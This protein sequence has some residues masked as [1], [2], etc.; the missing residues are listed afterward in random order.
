MRRE[1]I[2]S[3][4]PKRV[5][6]KSKYMLIIPAVA[7]VTNVKKK[8]NIIRKNTKTGFKSND[9]LSWKPRVNTSIVSKADTLEDVDKDLNN[10]SIKSNSHGSDSIKITDGIVD[11]S[12]CDDG[13]TRNNGI[14]GADSAVNEAY[15]RDGIN[16]DDN[17][18]CS[19]GVTNGDGTSAGTASMACNTDNGNSSCSGGVTNGDGTSAGTASMACN[20]DNG[21]SSCSGG[22]T[23][24][25]DT[26]AGTASMACNTD[27]SNKVEVEDNEE[28]E[29]EDEFDDDTDNEEEEASFESHREY[30]FYKEI[31][32]EV[33]YDGFIRKKLSKTRTTHN[34]EYSCT[35]CDGM[36]DH[37]MNQIYMKCICKLS[38][39]KFGY[40]Y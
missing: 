4:R 23:N 8:N 30:T 22:V 20:T 37:N 29:D 2:M 10:V 7:K 14:T 40:V 1:F 33:N 18:S 11:K 19:G 6:V 17:S 34:N 16:Y 5:T 31:V 28:E 38:T 39:C 9:E 36:K 27:S 35:M 13:V 24:G 21:N 3:E 12:C 25:D 32:G 15:L 26:S